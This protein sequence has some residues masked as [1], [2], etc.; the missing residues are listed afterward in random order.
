MPKG[1]VVALNGKV[2]AYY[3]SGLATSDGT[4]SCCIATAG[5]GTSCRT[6]LRLSLRPSRRL[7]SDCGSVR[8][9]AVSSLI[10]D[11]DSQASECRSIAVAHRY[12]GRSRAQPGV[13]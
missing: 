11:A 13:P 6:R 2:S 4:G 8:A 3:R 9:T 12:L 5:N 10:S 7:R 1:V